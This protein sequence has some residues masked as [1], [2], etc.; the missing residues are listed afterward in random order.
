MSNTVKIVLYHCEM[1]VLAVEWRL[2]T[3]SL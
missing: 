3:W 1:E 2:C